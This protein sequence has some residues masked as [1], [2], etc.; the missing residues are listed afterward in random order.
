MLEKLSM[1]Q[2]DIKAKLPI[3]HTFKLMGNSHLS[4]CVEQLMD[5]LE[6]QMR[7]F[8]ASLGKMIQEVK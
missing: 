4:R 5:R 3:T 2:F 8:S 6:Q 7:Y 1:Y